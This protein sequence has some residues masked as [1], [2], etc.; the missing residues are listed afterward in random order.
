MKKTLIISAAC[1]ALCGCESL[2][3]ASDS[4]Y[5]PVLV[6]NNLAGSD[7]KIISLVTTNGFVIRSGVRRGVELAG[8]LGFPYGGLV[9]SAVLGLLTIGASIRSRRWHQACISAVHAAN[10]FKRELKVVDSR[11]ANQLK[12]GI[13]LEQKTRGTQSLIQRILSS[14]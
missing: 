7:G 2:E 5:D 8:D 14:L 13:V 12:Q 11:R 9:S 6:T 10:E 4:L 3:R 1:L